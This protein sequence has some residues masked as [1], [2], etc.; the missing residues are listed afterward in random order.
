MRREAQGH[1]VESDS[2]PVYRGLYFN[3][4]PDEDGEIL[5]WLLAIPRARR[6]RAI[7]S[8]LR[9]G[10]PAYVAVRYHELTPLSA[11]AVRAALGGHR[12]TRS[13]SRGAPTGSAV[14]PSGR[15]PEGPPSGHSEPD[16]APLPSEPLGQARVV[17]EAKLDRLLQSFLR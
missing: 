13:E 6:M 17:V 12:R 11:E 1:R 10:L 9:T 15:P 14:L 5:G 8:A 4:A 16:S 7:K 3:L 2:R